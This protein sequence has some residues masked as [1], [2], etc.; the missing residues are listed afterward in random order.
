MVR[1][2]NVFP[3]CSPVSTASTACFAYI[4]AAIAKSRRQALSP[5]SQGQNPA[6]FLLTLTTSNQTPSDANREVTQRVPPWRLGLRLLGAAVLLVLIYQQVDL[7][8]FMPIIRATNLWAVGASMALI[9]IV[10][11]AMAWRLQSVAQRFELFPSYHAALAMLMTSSLAGFV[12]PGGLA[13]DVV[14]GV[15]LNSL[16]GKPKAALSAMLLDKYFGII[17]ILPLGV[18]ALLVVGHLLPRTI[19]LMFFAGLLGAVVVTLFARP[20]SEV[21]LKGIKLPEKVRSLLAIIAD[22]I[23][24]SRSF[25]GL[26]SLSLLIQILRSAATVALFYAFDVGINPV[27]AFV[28]IPVVVIVIIA[29]ISIGGLGVREGVLLALFLPLGAD[30]ERLVLVGLTG[31]LIELVS[32][33]PGFWYILRGLPQAPQSKV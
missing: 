5:I 4:F 27:L 19:S 11:L 30:A 9:I 29:P 25:A 8:E 3:I 26:L 28:Y 6:G 14:R 20:L 15:Q 1:I 17:A 12:L 10:R 33:L 22:H 24:M 21:W 32:A 13:Q 18:A 2:C 7:R 23:G 31:M 16:F